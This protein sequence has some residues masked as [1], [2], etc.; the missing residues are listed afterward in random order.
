MDLRTL[1]D[2]G[3]FLGGIGVIVSVLYLAIQIRDSTASQRSENYA[4]SLERM[5]AL[6][7]A[8]A[9]DGELV[10]LYARGLT[11]PESLTRVQRV[12][13]TWVLTEFFGGLEFMYYQS[14]HGTIPRELWMRW[15]ETLRW[16]LTFPGVAAWWQGK[17]APFTPGFSA[18]VDRCLASGFTPERPGAWESFLATGR[19]EPLADPRRGAP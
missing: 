1:A 3:E 9:G 15:E 17:P 13:F 12:R 16:W 5:A 2:L 6:Q 14:Q 4:R 8:M 10:A 11:E 7:Q 18:C 19:I